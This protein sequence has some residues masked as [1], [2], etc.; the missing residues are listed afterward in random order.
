MPGEHGFWRDEERCPSFCRYET[1]EEGD[2]CPIRPGEA[3]TGDLPAQ[4]GELM[5]EYEDLGV[6]GHGFHLM[7]ADGLE[8]AT[9]QAVGERKPHGGRACPCLSWL[10][11]PVW[12]SWTLQ[13]S[14]YVGLTA[15]TLLLAYVGRGLGRVSGC[16]IIAAYIA[17]VAVLLATA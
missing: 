17:F 16:A 3:G 1:G 11:K 12:C 13:A 7:H 9:R 14:W 10:V 4:H 8:Y 5:T 2:E 15:L 6:F